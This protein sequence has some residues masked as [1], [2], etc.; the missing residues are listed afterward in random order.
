M[1]LGQSVN[2]YQPDLG[3][4]VTAVIED[5]DGM[6]ESLAKTLTLTFK[7]DGQDMRMEKVPYMPDAAEGSPFWLM[8]GE[9]AP[10]KWQEVEVDEEAEV[11]V[12]EI[13]EDDEEVT[14]EE[15]EVPVSQR[16][17]KKRH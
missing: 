3:T 7:H 11:P 13:I 14:E 8:K 5:I 17:R 12:A 9:R 10:S 2:L 6:G 15:V 4:R 1:K 16:R